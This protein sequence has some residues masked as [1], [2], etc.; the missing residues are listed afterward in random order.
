MPPKRVYPRVIIAI[1]PCTECVHGLVPGP[2]ERQV[3]VTHDR[4]TTAIE[5]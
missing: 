5:R 2:V 4:E 3:G 1:Q